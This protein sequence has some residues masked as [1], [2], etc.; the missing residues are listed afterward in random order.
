[1]K[2]AGIAD[3]QIED[4]A[5]RI[6]E[7]VRPVA[8][9]Q[10]PGLARQR[11]GGPYRQPARSR[12]H[13]LRRRC[14]V[15]QFA[16]APFTS[17]RW[18]CRPG[19]RMSSSPAA[20]DTFNDIF[21]YMCFSKTPGALADRER[22]AVR[23]RRRRHDPRRGAGHGGAEAARRRRARRRHA[24]TRSSRASARRSDGKGNAIYAPSAAGQKQCSAERLRAGGRHARHDRTGRGPRHR[25]EGRRRD[26]GGRAHGGLHAAARSKRAGPGAR[27]AP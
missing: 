5:G 23:R 13:E 20:C 6:A 12:R 21:M 18:N 25:H 8:G 17:R 11:R 14:R 4:A 10:L 22:E 7:I 26:R 3:E 27:S 19:G 2:D 16:I 1:M 9:E 15:R 24:S